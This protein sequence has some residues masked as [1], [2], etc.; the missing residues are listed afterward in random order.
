MSSRRLGHLVLGTVALVSGTYVFVYIIRWEWDRATISALVFVASEVLLLTSLVLTRLQRLEAQLHRATDPRVVA[1]L[2]ASR[3]PPRVT[4]AWLDPKQGRTNVLVPVL[5]GAGVVLGGV[6]FV[7]ERVARVTAAPVAERALASRLSA[8]SLPSGGLLPPPGKPDPPDRPRSRHTPRRVVVVLLALALLS[9]GLAV[10]TE[11]LQTRTDT[12]VPSSTV[13]EL[14]VEARRTSETTEQIVQALWSSCQAAAPDGTRGVV[15]VTDP[16]AGVARL[17][18]T[19]GLGTFSARR[20]RG[21]LADLRIE[22][23]LATD[24]RLVPGGA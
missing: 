1:R 8:L 21:C 13:L 6:A 3:P 7:V 9:G 11:Q 16:D 12:V 24:V 18:L 2:A 14:T 23:V 19:P 22:R 20:L 4:F 5:M 10:L 17:T 15:V